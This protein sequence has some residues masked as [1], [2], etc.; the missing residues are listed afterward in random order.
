MAMLTLTA[1][2]EP[3][4]GGLIGARLVE[5]PGVITVGRSRRHA[6]EQ[7]VDALQEYLRAGA[8]ESTE[9]DTQEPTA[10]SERVPLRLALA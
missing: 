1:E 10:A 2:L 3:T 4:D 9:A 6:L 5:L 8:P 7:L